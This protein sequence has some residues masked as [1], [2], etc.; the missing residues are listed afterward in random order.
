MGIRRKPT[1]I[2]TDEIESSVSQTTQTQEAKQSEHDD[3]NH[4]RMQHQPEYKVESK[5][6][7]KKLNFMRIAFDYRY[8]V[9]VAHYAKQSHGTKMH[10][11]VDTF[12]FVVVFFIAHSDFLHYSL[13][14]KFIYHDLLRS[15]GLFFLVCSIY[16]NRQNGP[17]V[18]SANIKI[19][20]FFDF[21]SWMCW[22]KKRWLKKASSAIV[23][24]EQTES[25]VFGVCRHRKIWK[26]R[27]KTVKRRR[28]KDWD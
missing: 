10:F 13:C 22:S 18:A 4:W 17:Y 26:R 7:K 1:K 21:E 9:V 14:R 12:F 3:K 11:F 24:K 6:W 5:K 8:Y 2:A 15:M 27:K 20:S 28:T 25:C 23:L 16:L 19:K